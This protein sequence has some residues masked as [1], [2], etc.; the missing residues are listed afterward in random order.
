[1]VDR[2]LRAVL[3]ILAMGCV[4]L[5]ALVCIRATDGTLVYALD[6]A[7][8]HLGMGRTFAESGI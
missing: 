1:M 8:I 2:G 7:Y 5:L 6:D 3:C 4:A